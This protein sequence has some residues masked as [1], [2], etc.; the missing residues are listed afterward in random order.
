MF[1][2]M[3]Q[4][5]VFLLF[6]WTGLVLGIWYWL[7]RLLLKLPLL[8]K[9]FVRLQSTK[10]VKK[11]KL[12]LW[13]R[14]LNNAANIFVDLL[15]GLTGF[16]FVFLV[17]LVFNYGQARFYCLLAVALGVI[18]YYSTLNRPLDSL[19]LRLYNYTSRKTF[20]GK[21]VENFSEQKNDL[22]RNNSGGF[23]AR[24]AVL[25][26]NSSSAEGVFPSKSNRA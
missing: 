14:V 19:A 12:S 4:G 9:V 7:T 21:N 10:K 15:F 13:T 1:D 6:V 20:K 18:L 17:N 26:D 5:W 23:A 11:T 22:R 25:A 2:T 16:A 8:L 3:S 24:S